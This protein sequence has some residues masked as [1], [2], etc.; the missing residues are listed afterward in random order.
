VLNR[1][2]WVTVKLF[3]LVLWV[4]DSFGSRKRKGILA[5]LNRGSIQPKESIFQQIIGYRGK[6]IQMIKK[7]IIN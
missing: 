7:K 6:G 2:E 5:D 1:V 4:N 3:L